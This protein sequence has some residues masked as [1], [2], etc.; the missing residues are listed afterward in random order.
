MNTARNVAGLVLVA[1]ISMC[2]CAQASGRWDDLAL[3]VDALCRDTAFQSAVGQIKALT[4]AG[5][6]LNE[7]ALVKLRA[8]RAALAT[9]HGR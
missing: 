5:I 7:R 8:G 2:A 6:S 1:A 9:A 4:D 3:D